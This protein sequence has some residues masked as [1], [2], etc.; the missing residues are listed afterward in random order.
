M[1]VIRLQ[2]T[3]RKNVPTFRLVV[4]EKQ[5]GPKSGRFIDVVGSYDPRKDGAKNELKKDKI[6]MWIEKGAQPSDTV[7]NLLITEGVLE[8]KK[9][10]V[11]PKKTPV[12]KE[13]GAEEKAPAA[14]SAPVKEEV[15]KEEPAAEAEVTE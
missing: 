13:V 15:P 2:R 8:G 5:N 7:R 14:D 4:T 9:V 3:G 6:K 10:N 11:L 12:K 1:L